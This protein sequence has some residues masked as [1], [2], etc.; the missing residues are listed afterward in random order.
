MKIL[1]LAV[2]V[3]LA[4]CATRSSFTTVP[5]ARL[6]KLQNKSNEISERERLCVKQAVNRTNDQILQIAATPNT[7]VGLQMQ[8]AKND[9]DHE[10]SDC[11]TI[12]DREKA[13]LSARECTEYE[14]EAQRARDRDSLIG[15]L[16]T[17][18]PR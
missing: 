7:F 11:E 5:D 13:R 8:K 6:I 9:R 4:G 18:Q 2:A 15:I 1:T 12:A 17:S 16:T 3:L 14:E 10:I